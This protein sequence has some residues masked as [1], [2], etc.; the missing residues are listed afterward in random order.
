MKGHGKGRAG[1]GCG[2]G[3]RSNG[4]WLTDYGVMPR[5]A[6]GAVGRDCECSSC[7]SGGNTKIDVT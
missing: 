6:G 2:I 4:L 5:R 7:I 1:G 3:L